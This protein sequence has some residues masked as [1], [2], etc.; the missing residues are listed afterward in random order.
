M[1]EKRE[2]PAA[3][4]PDPGEPEGHLHPYP[5]CSGFWDEDQPLC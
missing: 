2:I 3:L 5:S 4:I 1:E